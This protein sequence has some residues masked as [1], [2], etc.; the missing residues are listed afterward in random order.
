MKILRHIIIY[1]SVDMWTLMNPMNIKLLLSYDF[2]ARRIRKEMLLE[3]SMPI[4]S[5]WALDMKKAIAD[6]IIVMYLW[7]KPVLCDN[8]VW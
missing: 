4:M 3:N 1:V 8:T 6:L 7:C 5:S 2:E